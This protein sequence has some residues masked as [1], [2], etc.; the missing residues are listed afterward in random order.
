MK[1]YEVYS[2]T[3]NS[4]TTVTQP[5]VYTNTCTCL[6]ECVS[7]FG[8]P[9]H[10]RPTLSPFPAELQESCNELCNCHYR[11]E[12]PIWEKRGREKIYMC[13]CSAQSRNLRTLETALHI[14]GMIAHCACAFSGSVYTVS[15]LPRTWTSSYTFL[16]RGRSTSSRIM[17]WT[18]FLDIV[19]LV[20]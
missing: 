14:S 9:P 17:F 1:D 4:I 20:W 16:L 13:V 19:L 3:K 18:Y 11:Y 15:G 2:I 12:Q 10:L 6:C 7:D 5:L 8:Q